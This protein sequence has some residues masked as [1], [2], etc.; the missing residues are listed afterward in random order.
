MVNKIFQTRARGCFWTRFPQSLKLSLRLSKTIYHG[1]WRITESL[2]YTL[3]DL[4]GPL[5]I[6]RFVDHDN[7]KFCV[8]FTVSRHL[9]LTFVRRNELLSSYHFSH[10]KVNKTS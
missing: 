8:P 4:W 3:T 5:T 9:P 7:S 6:D 1:Y 10:S 2:F